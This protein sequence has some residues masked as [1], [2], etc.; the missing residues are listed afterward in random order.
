MLKANWGKLLFAMMLALML[1]LVACSEDS[2]GNAD[3]DNND[4]GENNEEG[5]N[6]EGDDEL[7]IS[8][9]QADEDGAYDIEDFPEVPSNEGEILDDGDLTY[10]LVSES[11]FEGTLNANFYDGTPDGKI[12]DW[13]DESMLDYDEDFHYTDDGIASFE[14]DEDDES[15][16]FTLNDDIKWSD[17]EEFTMDDWKFAYEVI[18]HPAYEGIRYDA[19]ITNVEGVEEYHDDVEGDDDE[20]FQTVEE[21]REENDDTISGIEVID[22]ETM[23]ISYESL[24]G[25][26]LFGGIWTNAMPLHVF[27]DM[28]VEDMPS[29]DEVRSEPIGL[30]PY[31]VEDIQ[32]GESVTMSRNEH[33]WQG[34]PNLEEVTIKVVDDSSVVQELENGNVDIA[35]FPTDKY[36]DHEDM[37]NNEFLSVTDM[38]YTYIGFKL[39]SWDKDEGMVDP[40][41]DMKMGDRDLREAMWYALD[42]DEMADQFYHGFRWDADSLIPPSHENFHNDSLDAPTYDPDKANEILD[43]AGYEW[44]DDD[45]FRMTPDGEELKINFASMEGGDTAEPIAKYYM[46][47]WEE[48]GIDVELLDGRLQ[49]FDAFYE[50]VGDGGEDDPEVD[51]FQGAWSVGNDIDPSGIWGPDSISNFPRYQSDKADELIEKGKS[52]EAMDIDYRVGVYDEWQELMVEDIPAFPTVYR[53]ELKAVNARVANWDVTHH[54]EHFDRYE[55]GVTEDEAVVD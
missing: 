55:V 20:G 50:R 48:I 39:G 8:N 24:N 40:E 44:D 5:D 42:N 3:K 25:S 15:I 34:D 23:K 7:A 51:I 30:G 53:A 31:K 27:E 41:D 21:Y 47:S 36:P 22:D 14:V 28:P 43:D 52:E 18:A 54:N 37:T 12:L 19:S 17:G 46:Q 26:L 38:A 49:E 45:E 13:F 2:D 32:E 11:P 1:A 4:N 10:A 33:Y 9:P 29:S 35:D 16:T 6:N